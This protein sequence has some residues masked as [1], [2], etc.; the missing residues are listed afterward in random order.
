MKKIITL[1]FGILITTQILAQ[2]TQK[3][4]PI[5]RIPLLTANLSHDKK[6]QKVDI[7]QIDF[8][9]L[10]KAGFHSHPVAVVGYI[11]KGSIYFQME[12]EPAQTLKAGDAFFEPEN[13]KILH[14]D[15]PSQ[16]EPA[17]FIAFY[18]LGKN[19]TEIIQMLN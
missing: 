6:V 10:Q 19:D 5:V 1:I 11:A 4:E 7:K 2:G 18:L 12:G 16:T 14:F 8:A 9:P 13:K 3:P 17:T 15:N